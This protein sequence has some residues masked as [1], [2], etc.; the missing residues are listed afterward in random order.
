MSLLF[1]KIILAI[2]KGTPPNAAE[3]S[4]LHRLIIKLQSPLEYHPI[5]FNIS[6]ILPRCSCR[7]HN[8]NNC[9]HMDNRSRP[10]TGSLYCHFSNRTSDNQDQQKGHYAHRHDGQN[11]VCDYLTI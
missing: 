5:H 2:L 3:Q 4:V 8:Y 10:H 1:I 11:H 6:Y 7:C 9:N